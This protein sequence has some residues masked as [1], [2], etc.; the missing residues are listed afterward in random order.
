MGTDPANAAL[1][2][3]QQQ[4]FSMMQ[5]PQQQVPGSKKQRELYVGQLGQKH[6]APLTQCPRA[7]LLRL[8]GRAT[9]RPATASSGVLELAAS[10]V[11][12]STPLT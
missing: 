9:A 12:D 2:L 7:R 4:A 3:M 5:T 10:R 11:V 1:L 8:P 6:S